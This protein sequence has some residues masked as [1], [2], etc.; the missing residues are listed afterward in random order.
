MLKYNWGIFVY[1]FSFFKNWFFLSL[2]HHL[3]SSSQLIGT[4]TNSSEF[5]N[6]FWRTSCVTLASWQLLAPEAVRI[7][8]LEQGP[9]WQD[10][11]RQT[12]NR[13][14]Q[15]R[16]SRCWPW[17]ANTCGA[18]EE[19]MEGNNEAGRTG[20]RSCRRSIRQNWGLDIFGAEAE[21]RS[22]CRALRRTESLELGS[23]VART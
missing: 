22:C 20:D 18:W 10:V 4:L 23:F 7:S 16:Q 21:A 17:R 2:S 12:T 13:R 6:K 5:S 15:K 19:E 3:G 9:T 1:R 8:S 11:S 14:R